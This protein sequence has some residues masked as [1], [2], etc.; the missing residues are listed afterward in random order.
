VAVF[1]NPCLHGIY[2]KVPLQLEDI[3]VRRSWYLL[4]QNQNISVVF[5]LQCFKYRVLACIKFKY[6]VLACI[7]K[8]F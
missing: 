5:P 7:K 1:R 3:R 6:R 8:N 2:S 4:A